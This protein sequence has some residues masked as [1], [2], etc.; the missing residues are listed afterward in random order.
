MADPVL[1]LAPETGTPD[2]GRSDTTAAR[3]GLLRRYRRTLLLVVLPA[4]YTP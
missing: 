1:K 4:I 3:P 2:A